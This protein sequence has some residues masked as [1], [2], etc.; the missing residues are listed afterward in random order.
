[1]VDKW[2]G[3][4]ILKTLAFLLLA[5]NGV[6]EAPAPP[7]AAVKPYD[8]V[9]PRPSMNSRRSAFISEKSP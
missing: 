8:V 4:M 2:K 9:S 6:V 5:A 3:G 7:I 1:M